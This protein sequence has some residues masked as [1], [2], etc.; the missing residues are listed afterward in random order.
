MRLSDERCLRDLHTADARY[1][2]DCR[3][4]FMNKRKLSNIASSL[5]VKDNAFDALVKYMETDKS[6]VMTSVEVHT[7]Y[8]ELGGSITTRWLLKN[9]LKDFFGERL[10]VLSSPGIADIL[11]FKEAA[12]KMFSIDESDDDVIDTKSVAKEIVKEINEIEYDKN[13]YQTRQ[14]RSQSNVMQVA[15]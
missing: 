14:I 11:V 13:L 1:H 6:K 12:A 9:Q 8:L 3:K 7:K 10:L 4:T 2:E 5:A 15:N